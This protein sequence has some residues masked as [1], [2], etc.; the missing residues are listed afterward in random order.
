MLYTAFIKQEAQEK[1]EEIRIK[2]DKEFMAEKLQY[3]T[4]AR[5]VYIYVSINSQ[6]KSY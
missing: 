2:T 3:E 1:A 4:Q 6:D 5:Y